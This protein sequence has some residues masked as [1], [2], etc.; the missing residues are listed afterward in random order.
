MARIRTIKPEFWEDEKIAKLPFPCRLFYIG[1]WNFADDLG[2]IKSNATLLKSWIFPY[3]EDL[4]VSEIKKWIDALVDARMFVPIISNGESYYIIRTFRN[5]QVLDKR[6]ERS[7]LPKGLAHK[8]IEDALRDSIETTMCSHSN[9][10][11]NTTAEMEMEMEKEYKEKELSNDSPTKKETS[12]FPQAENKFFEDDTPQ[13]KVD[14]N[15]I[16][17]MYHKACPDYP[18]LIKLSDKRKAKIRVRFEEMKY[19]YKTVATIFCK[20]QASK[21]LKG[22]NK[23]GW[24]VGKTKMKDWK[25]AVRTWERNRQNTTSAIGQSGA[26]VTPNGLKLGK[27]EWITQD[28]RRTYGTGR[29]NIPMDA[30]PRPSEQYSWS[31]ETNKWIIL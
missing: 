12:S 25:A 16:V 6:Y 4:R 2:V 15:R 28:G 18:R 19:D 21:F 14:Y 29:A 10:I 30:P 1:C 20:M 7:Y 23:N 31:A 5:H 22:D 27:G 26:K 8:M 9:H 17:D 24:M 11:V 3:D 13:E